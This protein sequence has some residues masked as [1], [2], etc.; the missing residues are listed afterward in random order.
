MLKA[1]VDDQCKA[2]AVE[3]KNLKADYVQDLWVLELAFGL[4]TVKGRAACLN[5]F[6]WIPEL[7]WKPGRPQEHTS[8]IKN[9][10]VDP[11]TG[12]GYHRGTRCAGA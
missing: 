12:T 5:C 7:A 1:I 2:S 11:D 8:L 3:S 6:R 10:K 4:R 9:R